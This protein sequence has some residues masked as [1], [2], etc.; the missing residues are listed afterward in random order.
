MPNIRVL[1]TLALASNLYL[2]GVPTANAQPAP[3]PGPSYAATATPQED[4]DQAIVIKAGADFQR[5][6]YA[7]LEPHLAELKDVLA[8]APTA[9]PAVE[10]RGDMVILRSEGQDFLA[11]TIL[12]LAQASMAN[13]SLSVSRGFNTYPM[14]SLLLGAYADE[15]GRFADGIALLDKGLAL[16]PDN[17][18]LMSEKGFAL[19]KLNRPRDAL[20]MYE[21]GLK[22][23]LLT[24]PSRA[25]MLRGK[26][27][28]LI[29]LH[30]LDEAEKAYQ[31]ALKLEP[32]N[33]LTQGELKYIAQQRQAGR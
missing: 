23:S 24:E 25:R 31:A 3:T 4:A 30:R 11:Q 2:G 12:V 10:Y 19:N 28:A 13:K 26:G 29:E 8:H 32:G 1:L 15:K 7:G 27:Y 14:A 18:G 33:A 17:P 5:E 21:A 16:Q 6:R 9:F 20:A 22:V